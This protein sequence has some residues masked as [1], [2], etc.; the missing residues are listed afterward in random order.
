MRQRL[1]IRGAILYSRD[2]T[3]R[4]PLNNP[5]ATP[6]MT[7]LSSFEVLSQS[8]IPNGA[9]TIPYVVQAYFVQVSYPTGASEDPVTF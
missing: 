6:P 4:Q 2:G 9:A 1:N 8:L 7:T 5:F 3:R